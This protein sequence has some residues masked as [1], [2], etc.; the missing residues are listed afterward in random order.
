MANFLKSS[1]SPHSDKK[2]NLRRTPFML[3]FEV[4]KIPA[5]T[6]SLVFL[7]HVPRHKMLIG[8][9]REKPGYALDKPF[10]GSNRRAR[11][12]ERHVRA[13]PQLVVR[14]CFHVI[15]LRLETA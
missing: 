4:A 11:P 12:V 2:E 10:G 8:D 14:D 7:L 3:H 6:C 1:R 15:R 13:R 9:L 5:V